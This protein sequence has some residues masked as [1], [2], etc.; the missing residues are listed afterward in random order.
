MAP[1]GDNLW[2]TRIARSLALVPARRLPTE[3][4]DVATTQLG[5]GRFTTAFPECRSDAHGEV[6]TACFRRWE[7]SLRWQRIIWTHAA[8]LEL[9]VALAR[10]EADHGVWPTAARDLVPHYLSRMPESPFD[11]MGLRHV[12]NRAWSRGP[13]EDDDGGRPLSAPY[14]STGDGDIVVEV[15]GHR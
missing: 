6:Q 1:A 8:V 12:G 10:F 9:A 14:E 13:D 2:S 15:K 5:L 7:Y 11:P 4:S 3:L